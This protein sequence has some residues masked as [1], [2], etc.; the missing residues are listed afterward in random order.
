MLDFYYGFSYKKI[1]VRFDYQSSIY[2][3][4]MSMP[5]IVRIGI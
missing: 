1:T 2:C 5:E 3:A 4:A